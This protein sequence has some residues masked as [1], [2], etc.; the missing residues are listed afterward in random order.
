MPPIPPNDAP[1]GPRLT[2][3]TLGELPPDEAAAVERTLADDPAARAHVD[4]VRRL[5]ADLEAGFNAQEPPSL[6]GSHLQELHAMTDRPTTARSPIA[7]RIAAGLGVLAAAA[8]V[9]LLIY[10]PMQVGKPAPPSTSPSTASEGRSAEL[11]KWLTAA[12]DLHREGRHAEAVIVAER[13]LMDAPDDA[14]AH[15]LRDAAEE[16]WLLDL[17][18]KA[19]T[20]PEPAEGSEAAG[21]EATATATA[22][23]SELMNYAKLADARG[24]GK[25]ARR[26]AQM[27]LKKDKK[28]VAARA[29]HEMD[30]VGTA[31][32][33]L[34][35]ALTFDDSRRGDQT[36]LRLASGRYD[37]GRATAS[38]LNGLASYRDF[39]RR[40][41]LDRP[42]DTSGFA[43]SRAELRPKRP[44]P[45]ATLRPAAE[46]AVSRPPPANR[47]Q[48]VVDPWGGKPAMK[49]AEA[50]RALRG[51]FNFRAENQ[52]GVGPAGFGMAG[53]RLRRD[54]YA[55]T[56]D[57]PWHTATGADAEPYSTFSIDV[58]TA[59]YAIVRRHLTEGTLPPIDA[60]RIEELINYFSYDYD[61]PA[62]LRGI[63]KIGEVDPFSADIAVASAPW[64]A[65]HRLVRIGIQAVEVDPGTRPPANLVFLLDVSGSMS[66]S[67]KLPLLKTA[68]SRLV[69]ELREDDRVAIVVYA[70]ASGLVLPSTPA[71]NRSAILGSLEALRSGGST[72][73]AAGIQLAYKIAEDHYIDGGI[74]R[75]LL[76]TDGDFNVGVSDTHALV[77][78]AQQKAGSKASVN[79]EAS[80]AHTDA[81]AAA[82][83]A[84]AGGPDDHQPVYLS[85][86]GFGSGNLNDEM[87]ERITNA[88]NGNYHYIDSVKEAE[89][90][91]VEQAGG[92]LVTVA[93][94]VKLQVEFN[95]KHVQAYRLI[96]Y[97][98][99]LLRAQEFN[100][101]TVDAG[102]IGA[103]HTVTAFYEVV[104]AGLAFSP[105][106]DAWVGSLRSRLLQLKLI[107]AAIDHAAK[108]APA[109]QPGSAEPDSAE[110]ASAGGEDAL[111]TP[112]QRQALFDEMNASA[113]ALGT[114]KA[115]RLAKRLPADADRAAELNKAVAS[116]RGL[117]QIADMTTHGQ[118]VVEAEIAELERLAALPAPT[119]IESIATEPEIASADEAPA[120]QPDEE[121]VAS[122]DPASAGGSDEQP[123]ATQPAVDPYRYQLDG[124]LTDLGR[125]SGEMLA[126]K[127]RY[128]RPDAAA[129]QGTSKRLLFPV[130]DEGQRFDAMDDDYR[131]AACVAG[132]GML[133]RQ[134]EYVGGFSWD[135][136]IEIAE[137]AVSQ[138]QVVGPDHPYRQEFIEL[139]EQARDLMEPAE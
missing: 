131:F 32:R 3:Y 102:D 83:P 36:G 97:A 17:Y 121:A 11:D 53:E 120:T 101:D 110:P 69:A 138:R 20:A 40:G 125:G 28:N 4:A 137:P 123:P 126:V 103:G 113:E 73:G 49:Q 54:A 80:L 61:P 74:N 134:S 111:P 127:L 119:F 5:A 38:Q 47:R 107:E 108:Q 118:L 60:V 64:N 2:A 26:Y 45:A 16:A 94:D 48:R 57:N 41:R 122:A 136:L 99:R 59:S 37:D 95:P 82:E 139:A 109:T 100:D 79:E 129:E 25:R 1:N 133:L 87:M 51:R 39:E 76:A 105:E 71:S 62:M 19:A 116:L 24:D 13:V 124:D 135:G 58:D 12:V 8:A 66:S 104:P 50:D 31:R 68:F 84:S 93:K 65:D 6:P 46:P 30:A 91:L 63:E 92:T 9:G 52:K 98:N 27:S 7:G 89:K 90:V 85:V 33:S 96:G 86:F 70:G 29:M 10:I 81:D 75:V 117:L 130:K 21:L 14:A 67:D 23:A 114:A 44:T 15:A 22:T 106:Q 56:T 42:G 34:T 18:V 43:L 55:N 115:R 88:G 78:L 132:Y 112:E 35:Y 72:A 77:Q 128:K